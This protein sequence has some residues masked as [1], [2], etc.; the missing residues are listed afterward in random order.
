MAEASII[1]FGHREK[2]QSL[3]K[4]DGEECFQ[5][6]SW[7]DGFSHYATGSR[8]RNQDMHDEKLF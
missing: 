2:E 3:S 6:F 8:R 1:P 7:S 4:K 5:I